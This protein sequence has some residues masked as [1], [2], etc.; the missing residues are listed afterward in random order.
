MKDR[1]RRIVYLEKLRT[2]IIVF[3]ISLIVD[4]LLILLY[5]LAP[6]WTWGAEEIVSCIL[7][8]LYLLLVVPSVRYFFIWLKNFDLYRE[9]RNIFYF[10]ICAFRIAILLPPYYAVKYYFEC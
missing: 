6:S 3:I 8:C 5:I 10:A 9:N 1:K 7:V 4:G 2:K